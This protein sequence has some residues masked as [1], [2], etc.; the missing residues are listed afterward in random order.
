MCGDIQCISCIFVAG[1]FIR[2]CGKR[3][4]IIA[5]VSTLNIVK[6]SGEERTILVIQISVFSDFSFACPNRTAIKLKIIVKRFMISKEYSAFIPMAPKDQKSEQ[7][8]FEYRHQSCLS[9]S[10]YRHR[11][12]RH[13]D[14]SY[15]FSRAIFMNCFSDSSPN[16]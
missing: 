15:A 9:Y 11:C 3:Y 16:R 8:V 2:E 13:K 14:Y 6:K 4:S 10:G 5:A 7:K 1:K 12:Y